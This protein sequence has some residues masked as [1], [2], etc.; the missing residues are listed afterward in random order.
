MFDLSFL[1]GVV[2]PY[3]VT[4]HKPIFEVKD[5]Q[6]AGVDGSICKAVLEAKY[7]GLVDGKHLYGIPIRVLNAQDEIINE[8][9]RIGYIRD[10]ETEM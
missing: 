5:L 7:P 1:D 3:A 10:R 9:K 6:Y 2:D 8:V 4:R